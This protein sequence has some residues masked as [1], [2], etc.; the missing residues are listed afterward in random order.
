MHSIR[1]TI[2]T[3]SN[4]RFEALCIKEHLGR[5]QQACCRRCGHG[6][7]SYS[8]HRVSTVLAARTPRLESVA[9]TEAPNQGC[10]RCHS[11]KHGKHLTTL[12][13]VPKW[14]YTT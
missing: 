7:I 2:T 11:P 9:H 3:S 8:P 10:S 12:K 14:C 6:L 5:P 1:A 4:S 13:L